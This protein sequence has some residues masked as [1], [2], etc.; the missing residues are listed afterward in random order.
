MPQMSSPIPVKKVEPYP[1][2]TETLQ[3]A[4]AANSIRFSEIVQEAAVDTAYGCDLQDD[5]V[6]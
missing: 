4:E 1:V 6:P 5:A 3:P 2:T